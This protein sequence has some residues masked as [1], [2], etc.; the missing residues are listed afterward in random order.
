[1]YFR[2]FTGACQRNFARQDASEHS[3]L[4]KDAHAGKPT[5]YSS[6][7]RIQCPLEEITC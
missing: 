4:D 7:E 2:N 3:Q 6:E 1:M 5:N